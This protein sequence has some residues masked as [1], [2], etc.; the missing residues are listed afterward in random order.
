MGENV[1]REIY[2][3][4]EYARFLIYPLFLVM[5]GAFAYGVYGRYH[6][7]HLGYRENRTDATWKRLLPAL[8]RV[9]SQLDLLRS[10]FPGIAHLLLFWGFVLLTIGTLLILVQEDLLAPLAGV[11]FLTGGFYLGYSLV[12][13]L[14]G[15]VA[16]VATLLFVYRRYVARP[17]MLLNRGEDLAIL[18]LLLIVLLGG[19]FV[20]AVRI[21][22]TGNA[23]DAWSLVGWILAQPM[24]GMD[25]RTL[26]VLHTVGW[27]SHLLFAFGLLGYIGY[28]K[29]L[30]IVTGPANLFLR[31]LKPNGAL[32]PIE[33]I[34]EAESYGASSAKEFTWKQLF[35]GDACMR[36]GRCQDN[37]PAWNTHKPLSPRKIVLDVREDLVEHG[38]ATRA[39]AKANGAEP[40]LTPR[41][42]LVGGRIGDEELWSC[43]TCRACQE[44][45]PV[46]V[47]HIQKII[48][49][50]RYL[51]LNESRFPKELN[52][53]FNNVERNGN[54]W[55]INNSGRADWAQGLG[56]KTIAEAP[57]AEYLL[58]VGCFGSYDD[59]NRKVSVALAR[60]L[61]QAG[62]SFAILGRDEKCCGDPARRAG[63]EY[64]YQMMATENIATLDG[65]G[66]K[67]IITA[68]PHCFN[69]IKNEYPQFGGSYDVVHHTV[70]LADLIARGKI[71]LTRPFSGTLTLHDPCYLGRHNG[72]YEE[73]RRLLRA[74]PG[75]VLVEMPRARSEA[76]CCGGGG[77]RAFMEEYSGEKINVTR[78]AQ[79]VALSSDVIASACP[80]CMTMI[81]DGI[82][83]M[84]IEE[85]TRSMDIAEL[86]L[87]A[88]R[89]AA[90]AIT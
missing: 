34:E 88:S 73:P 67:K 90:N 76:M 77:A 19:F 85:A 60:L 23:F 31:S 29:L 37:C 21:A 87:E 48:D 35:D 27:W 8:W 72:V 84:G 32:A 42:A 2:W 69:T 59:R 89:P 20:E 56:V 53:V 47:E 82:K 39:I 52:S 26:R 9:I 62:V 74:I 63:N 3:N 70:F 40:K 58:W 68:C 18:L 41:A 75:A 55:E 14:T 33:N 13:D 24:A 22:A 86:L 16:M 78:V 28:S 7:W 25:Q 44:H 80:Y 4:V 1:T 45:C 81:E 50:R 11:H 15:L 65:C 71:A 61:E 51:V 38:A 12:L 36:C 30:H 49:M 83:T 5:L 43:T 54:P 79:A 6:L 64:L 10:P 66:V 17:E 57:D 46:S